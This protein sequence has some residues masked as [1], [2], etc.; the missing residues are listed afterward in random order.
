MKERIV[1]RR[2]TFEA[3]ET[4]RRPG[5]RRR[6]ITGTVIVGAVLLSGLGVGAVTATA[7]PIWAHSGRHHHRHAWPLPTVSLDGYTVATRWR[8]P[9]SNPQT[10]APAE[11]TAAASATVSATAGP[12]SS[13]TKATGT[14]TTVSA[15]TYGTATNLFAA[16]SPWN[17]QIPANPAVDPQSSA[18]SSKVLNNPSLVVNLDLISYGQPFFTATA[19]TP[20]VVLGGRGG[21]S[22]LGAVPLDPSWNANA[23]ADSKMNIVDPSTHTV[24]ELQGFN[25]AAKSV[26]WAV[27]HDYTTALG[28]GYPTNGERKGPTGSAMSQAAGT[29]RASDL[30]AGV[31]D[32]ALTFLTSKPVGCGHP[33]GHA[34]PARPV[35]ER[36]R[37][38]RIVVRREDG[39]ESAA[40]VRRLLLRQRRRERP[41]DGL[42]R[43]EAELLHPVDLRRG[44]SDEGLAGPEQDPPGQAAGAGDI[45]DPEALSRT[46]DAPVTAAVT[47]ASPRQRCGR[48][49][50]AARM[51]PMLPMR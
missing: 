1:H 7:S 42:L 26:Y 27:K 33:G 12:T 4:P 43:R 47:G 51:N 29:I 20:R 23:G 32:H 5:G 28:D 24:F 36:R 11:A 41:G 31:I 16:D 19:S 49:R 30:K 13:A 37:D 48:G 21:G 18:I 34:H 3:I 14:A 8:H 45:G 9:A 17:T 15:G 25:A 2:E 22:A 44:G 10:S 35:R 39:D 50:S 40:D 46:S 38:Q 6:R